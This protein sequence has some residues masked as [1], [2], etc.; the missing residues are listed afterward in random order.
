M[1]SAIM[2]KVQAY[3]GINLMI[4]LDSINDN[5]PFNTP[6]DIN[7][8]I[9]PCL[10]RAIND[11]I[12]DYLSNP[13]RIESITRL[14]QTFEIITGNKIEIVDIKGNVKAELITLLTEIINKVPKHIPITI[15]GYNYPCFKYV[16]NMILEG[17][18][19]NN[20][21]KYFQE[22]I[23]EIFHIFYISGYTSFKDKY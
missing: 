9:V 8:I 21:S 2:Q 12:I 15:N 10:R 13:K 20:N 17:W 7:N 18:I 1:Q 4:E 14:K 23:R 5:I 11:I 19:N 22:R 6:Y 3:T 16:I